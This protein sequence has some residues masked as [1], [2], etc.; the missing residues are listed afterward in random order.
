MDM[1]MLSGSVVSV[2]RRDIERGEQREA[3]ECAIAR[4]L[5]RTTGKDVMVQHFRIVVGDR[6]TRRACRFETPVAARDFIA[7]F[8]SRDGGKEKSK[9]F[10][11]VLSKGRKHE[12][13]TWAGYARALGLPTGPKG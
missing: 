3:T 1:G 11:F 10:R 2:T 4:S 13:K 12:Y 6:A 8:D 5:R 9:P 7:R